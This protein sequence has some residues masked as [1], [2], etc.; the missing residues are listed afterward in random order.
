[1]SININGKIIDKVQYL[2]HS[3]FK[4]ENEYRVN[5]THVLSDVTMEI[6]KEM[7][8]LHILFNQENEV[9]I[10]SREIVNSFN[11]LKLCFYHSLEKYYQGTPN[12]STLNNHVTVKVKSENINKMIDTIYILYNTNNSIIERIS[13]LCSHYKITLILIDS[14]TDILKYEHEH[15]CESLMK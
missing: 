11:K 3:N 5:M 13:C 12:D 9:E 4:F 15:V 8:N 14:I 6:S 10:I 2:K 1:L 7:Q